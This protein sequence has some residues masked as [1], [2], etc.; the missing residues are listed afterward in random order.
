MYQKDFDAWHIVKK[1]INDIL[2]KPFFHERE[3]WYLVLSYKL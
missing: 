3:V 1:Q 2:I